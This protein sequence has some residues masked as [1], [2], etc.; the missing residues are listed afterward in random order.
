MSM[1]ELNVCV[2]VFVCQILSK[3]C[4]FVCVCVSVCVRVWVGVCVCVCVMYGTNL[5]REQT[6]K[7][8][9]T[10]QIRNPLALHLLSMP[11]I[12]CCLMPLICH[13]T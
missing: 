9:K 4:A 3:E 6:L 1:T 12:F 2:S 10:L 13:L 11:G 5:S 8:T 7:I